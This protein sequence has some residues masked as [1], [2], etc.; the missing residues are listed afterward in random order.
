MQL[1]VCQWAQLWARPLAAPSV[2]QWVPLW[3]QQSAELP[4]HERDECTTV[5]AVELEAVEDETKGG[6]STTSA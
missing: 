2:Y 6:A 1:P 5:G 4:V 3:A